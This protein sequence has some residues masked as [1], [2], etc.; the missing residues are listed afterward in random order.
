MLEYGGVR[1]E[2][3][4]A[5]ENVLLLMP[6]GGSPDLAEESARLSIIVPVYNEERTVLEVVRRLL[7]VD[8]GCSIEIIVVNDGSS[9]GTADALSRLTDSSVRVVTHH[10]NLGKGAAL[11]SG[12]AVARGEYMV[13]FDAD[14][15][16]DPQDL[17]KLMAPILA[18]RAS[19]VYGTRIFGN[20][21]VYQSYR[22]AMGN[23]VMTLAANVL[24]DA[25]ITDLH[26]CLKVVPVELFRD[27]NLK[28][29]GFGLD[30]ELT[31]S[32]LKRGYR[33]FEVPVSYHSR[34]HAEGKKITWVDAVECFRTLGRVRFQKAARP[35]TGT[36]STAAARVAIPSPRPELQ[37][38][39]SDET[40]TPREILAANAAV[41]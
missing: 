28:H 27:L 19:I 29:S 18:G 8:Y 17:P 37:P 26:T 15:E 32:L 34:S 33:P 39:R 1:H 41:G 16:Y 11:R 31:A 14:L 20:H 23:K 9:D 22:Y 21:T 3:A 2:E 38:A 35:A 30:T 40:L 12:A 5:E 10:V 24:F 36:G 25:Y 4:G 13:P 6:H 7:A